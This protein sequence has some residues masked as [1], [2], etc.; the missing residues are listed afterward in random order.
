MGKAKQLSEGEKHCIKR[1]SNEEKS[2]TWMSKKVSR[3]I[4]CI[5]TCLKDTEACG[6]RHK[7]GKAKLNPA[8]KGSSSER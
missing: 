8:K 2:T 7:G 6:K 4:S 3:S 1:K 5:C